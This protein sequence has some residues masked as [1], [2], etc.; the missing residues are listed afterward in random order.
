[1]NRRGEKMGLGK[2]RDAKWKGRERSG[3]SLTHS[4]LVSGPSVAF[5]CC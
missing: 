2:V 5:A 4:S 3:V 1:M